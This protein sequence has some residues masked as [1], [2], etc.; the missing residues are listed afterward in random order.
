[1]TSAISLIRKTA[2]AAMFLA[3]GALVTWPLAIHYTSPSSGTDWPAWVQAVGSIIAIL[4]AVAVPLYVNW[5][6]EASRTRER[7]AILRSA[8]LSLLA[9]SEELRNSIWNA[10]WE[11]KK[12]EEF[13]DE[14]L[15]SVIQLLAAPIHIDQRLH[16]LHHIDPIG[17]IIQNAVVAK[18]KA[19]SLMTD[20]EFYLG[21]G[22]IA[23]GADGQRVEITEP[24]P[25]DPH[26]QRAALLIDLAVE[27][28]R[29]RFPLADPD[30]QLP[31]L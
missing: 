12:L 2:C 22:G 20:R 29:K 25:Y 28:M 23:Y 19:V 1:M 5:L 11:L 21:S 14:N 7:E 31:E 9:P 6:Q 17:P 24:D 27:A 3:L 8:T 30:S 15:P 18:A 16:E 13:A 4:V 26:L 10:V